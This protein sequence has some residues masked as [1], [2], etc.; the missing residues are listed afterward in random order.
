MF[1]DY[2]WLFALVEIFVMS[3]CS[4]NTVSAEHNGKS[5]PSFFKLKMQTVIPL[6]QSCK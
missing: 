5:H 4:D 3:P 6:R 2:L 1:F